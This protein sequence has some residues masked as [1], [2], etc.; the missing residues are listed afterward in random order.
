MI[1]MDRQLDM[2]FI[3][4]FLFCKVPQA[5]QFLIKA[6]QNA[7]T[8]TITIAIQMATITT[9]TPIQIAITMALTF[10]IT[11]TITLTIKITIHIEINCTP[12]YHME[13]TLI[14]NGSQLV[15]SSESLDI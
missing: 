3:V 14:D 12:H 8:T 1:Y 15:V 10:K 4:H 9:M 6:Y 2:Y 7:S 5:Q 11:T 13:Y